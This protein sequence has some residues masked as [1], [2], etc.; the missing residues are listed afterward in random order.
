MS[1]LAVGHERWGILFSP[2]TVNRCRWPRLLKSLP[3]SPSV[4]MNGLLQRWLI[5]ASNASLSQKGTNITAILSKSHQVMDHL[6]SQP[7]LGSRCQ[8]V[9][10]HSGT[11]CPS[12]CHKSAP[13]EMG[14]QEMSKKSALKVIFKLSSGQSVFC[15][16]LLPLCFL[17]HCKLLKAETLEVKQVVV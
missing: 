6:E 15:P 12:I 16:C 5:T 10:G 4:I 17:R 11:S 3:P 1:C 13:R 9:E 2:C 7:V 8:P 14:C